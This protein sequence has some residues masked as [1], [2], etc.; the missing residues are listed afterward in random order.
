METQL[1]RILD[2][3][4]P[5]QRDAVTHPVEAE[6]V[7][8]IVGGP[9][10]ILAGPGTGK[11]HVLTRRIAHLINVQGREP[12]GVLALTFTVK[13]ARELKERIIGFVG[14]AKGEGVRCHTFNGYGQSLI[15]RFSHYLGLPR[16]L[17]MID[18]VQTGR[19]LTR[20]ILEEGLFPYARGRGIAA[21]ADEVAAT[22]EILTNLGATAE[23]C[24]DAAVR[25][26]ARLEAG[27][28]V[29]N[30][31][32]SADEATEAE[33][34]RLE[35]FRYVV[36]AMGR[37]NSERRGLGWVSYADQVSMPLELL[38][39]CPPA[40]AAI[41]GELKSVIVDEFQD[42]NP[43]QIMLLHELMGP[44]SHGGRP[45]LTVVGDDDQA[46]YGFRGS[47]DRAFKRFETLWAGATP[48]VVTLRE[49]HRSQPE[50]IRTA[51]DV[52]LAAG[53]RFRPE[54]VVEFPPGKVAAGGGVRAVRLT[55][56][57]DD[58]SVVPAILIAERAAAAREGR[59]F[60]WGDCA[61]IGRSHTDLARIAAAL[62]VYEIPFNRAAARGLLTLPVVEDAL[63]WIAW[64]LEPGA[65]WQARRVLIR[66]P[67]GLPAHL[68]TEW[69]KTYCGLRGREEAGIS[70]PLTD[71]NITMVGGFDVAEGGEAAV[72]GGVGEY[73]AWLAGV[74]AGGGAGEHVGVL[75]AALERL[76]A[77]RL[78]VAGMR[79]DDAVYEI[80]HRC[81]VPAVMLA[82][83]R[84]RELQLAGVLE[85]LTFA[86]EKQER[87]DQPRMLRELHDYLREWGDLYSA[88]VERGVDID[89]RAEQEVEGVSNKVEL[90]TAHASKG[91]E[92]DTVIVPRVSPQHGF[93]KTASRQA[94]FVAPPELFDPLD[95]RDHKL[96][97]LD[98]ERR[99]FYV[100]CTRAKRRL[101]LLAKLN[102]S[103]SNS[104]HFFEELVPVVGEHRVEAVHT[105]AEITGLAG[106]QNISGGG[107]LE[108]AALAE[109]GGAARAYADRVR[110]R[111]RHLI[112]SALD[113]TGSAG[114]ETGELERLEAILKE[115]LHVIA[116]ANITERTRAAAGWGGQAGAAAEAAGRI[117]GA[118]AGKGAG[119]S[120][121]GMV[122]K[123]PAGPL[124]ISYTQLAAFERCP[125]C[126]YLNY[127][128]GVASRESDEA[129]LGLLVHRTL[130]LY[131]DE[132]REAEAAGQPGPDRR[133][134]VEL[135]KREYGAGL[136]PR[137]APDALL[138]DRLLAQ[139]AAAAET[140]HRPGDQILELERKFSLPI[141]HG[142]Q[143]HQVSGKIDR[144]DQGPG[145]ELIIIDYKT[146]RASQDK[147]TPKKDDL[148]LGLYVLAIRAMFGEATGGRAEY[149]LLGEGVRGGIAFEDMDLAKIMK[150][151]QGTIDG[152]L[153]GCYESGAKCEGDCRLLAPTE[154]TEKAEGKKTTRAKK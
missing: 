144:I 110:M 142:G 18:E 59:A 135:A 96:R 104:T 117:A 118:L 17:T 145:G 36:K 68:V 1:N 28:I 80:L 67:V 6:Q 125:R 16:K 81:V 49:N 122:F 103:P 116:A 76:A 2:G 77:V 53:S 153:S 98:E 137:Q 24:A 100:A 136:D 78:A 23:A 69:E 13:A 7:G 43:S 130:E 62:A 91:L 61:V 148:Q 9:L 32:L 71:D 56:D 83:G 46:I 143:T 55:T 140:L 64:V 74:A 119:S 38:R 95:E 88:A 57:F 15:T 124:K 146:G 139:A 47:D 134:L 5:P 30:G 45:D 14:R 37:Y 34:K 79:G 107:L 131:F 113:A 41:R 33:R 133:R 89:D 27:A 66:P 132:V 147:R 4:N 51:N 151:V 70:M 92:F 12:A 129:N 11:T 94:V 60:S 121:S 99:L 39:A 50:I 101:W 19:L 29:S 65:T 10:I 31:L 149:W 108:R 109:A 126:W 21:L 42:C 111:A 52:I 105:A 48:R 87:L 102:K 40:A 93:P 8:A 114:F 112:A 54:K 86:R 72:A 97:I 106:E 115:S 120:N 44:R 3:L 84:E 22:I 63:A 20:I 26:A 128:A 75:T 123:G 154:E 35:S 138:L 150:Q 85:L 90:L 73:E 82:P 58:A 25:W 127:V 152:M 141:E